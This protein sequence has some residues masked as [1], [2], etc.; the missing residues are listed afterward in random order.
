MVSRVGCGGAVSRVGYGGAVARVGCG[1][2]V[3]RVG[4][5]GVVSR[6]GCGGVIAYVGGIVILPINL[7]KN[8]FYACLYYAAQSNLALYANFAA[9]DFVFTSV[10]RTAL[11]YLAISAVTWRIIP[12]HVHWAFA[13]VKTILAR[14]YLAFLFILLAYF[15]LEV[16]ASHVVVKA[17]IGF[18]FVLCF[19]NFIC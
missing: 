10:N 9:C 17:L 1:G 13:G 8:E 2:A 12:K 5:G 6:V 16:A 15:K 3:S 14:L 11:F 18:Y 7:V 4:C 19:H